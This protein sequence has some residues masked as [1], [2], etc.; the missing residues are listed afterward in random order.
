MV[1][2]VYAASSTNLLGL[3][4]LEDAADQSHAQ[5][6]LQ[7]SQPEQSCYDSPSKS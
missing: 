4:E 6:T 5:V 2:Q 3:G 1:L 7:L